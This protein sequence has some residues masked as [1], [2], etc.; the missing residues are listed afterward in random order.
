MCGKTN[1]AKRGIGFWPGLMAVVLMAGT[2]GELRAQMPVGRGR[3]LD[4][5]RQVGSGGRNA[6][7]GGG[8]GSLNN[9]IISGNVGAGKSFQGLG[10][11]GNFRSFQG[12]LG[13]SSLNNFQ[14]D[15]YGLSNN[16]SGVGGVPKSFFLPSSTVLGVRG[17]T[18]GRARLG[19]N[20]PRNVNLTPRAPSG[21]SL[22][23]SGRLSRFSSSGPVNRSLDLRPISGGLLPGVNQPVVETANNLFGIRRLSPGLD[24]NRP[25]TGTL[26]EAGREGQESLPR[27]TKRSLL[28]ALP[29]WA[30]TDETQSEGGV[31]QPGMVP[32]ASVTD[33]SIEQNRAKSRELIEE[34]QG[35]S[36]L[37]SLVEIYEQLLAKRRS[38]QQAE[39]VPNERGLDLATP[40]TP[41]LGEDSQIARQKAIEKTLVYNMLAGNRGDAFNKYMALGESLLK[42]GNYYHAARAYG[43]AIRLEGQNPLGY[44]GRAYS[45]AGAGELVS[46]AED[47]SRALTIFPE[48]VQAKIDLRKFFNS[49]EEI[50]RITAKLQMLAEARQTD[51]GIRLLLGYIYHYSGKSHLAGPILSEAAELARTDP[52][53]SPELA[54]TI[55]KFAKAVSK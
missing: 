41:V 17:V 12:S 21:P 7:V 52:R 48:Q 34:S 5:N 44:L 30:Q 47:L 22:G 3:G 8:V 42:S 51:A 45:L 29:A 32:D 6:G 53:I 50:N 13:T 25:Y 40:F 14:R 19:S 28:Q 11:I 54:A 35:N 55:A 18:S 16:A 10:G 9:R 33:E 43:R 39:A 1:M 15:S 24:L 37:P 27:P 26:E 20:M 38:E 23:Q 2:A 31:L 46:A 49:P 36:G 4:A